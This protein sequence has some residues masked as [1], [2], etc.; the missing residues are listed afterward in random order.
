MGVNTRK[1]DTLAHELGHVL[2]NDGS[3]S[4]DASNLMARGAIRNFTDTLTSSQI[5]AIQSSPYVR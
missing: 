2:T 4:D 1:L 3:H 5:G